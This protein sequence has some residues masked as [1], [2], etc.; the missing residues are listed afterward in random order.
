MW[1]RP[2]RICRGLRSPSKASVS[3]R[4]PHSYLNDHRCEER[5]HNNAEPYVLILKLK[6]TAKTVNA[7]KIQNRTRPHKGPCSGVFRKQKVEGQWPDEYERGELPC[8]IEHGACHNTLS[9]ACPHYNS[10][11]HYLPIFLDGFVYG[12]ALQ[13]CSQTRFDEMIEEA[14]GSRLCLPVVPALIKPIR[15]HDDARPDIV[16]AAPRCKK[17]F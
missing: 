2:T 16:V 4:N 9:W 5:H 8:A 17:L 7:Q 12:R 6:R 14:K 10:T 11:I 13:I 15:L 1:R 3:L